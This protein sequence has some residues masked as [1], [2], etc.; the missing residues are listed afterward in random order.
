ML[1]NS[2]YPDLFSILQSFDY[3]IFSLFIFVR[4]RQHHDGNTE[5]RD[6]YMPISVKTMTEH[7]I[8]L[9]QNPT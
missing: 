5:W 1:R 4:L 9:K 3:F 6:M 7:S 2:G 8:Y